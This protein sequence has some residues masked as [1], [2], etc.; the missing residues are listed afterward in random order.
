[1]EAGLWFLPALRQVYRRKCTFYNLCPKRTIK[2]V[3]SVLRFE[4][5]DL[6]WKILFLFFCASLCTLDLLALNIQE[7]KFVSEHFTFC[8]CV[9]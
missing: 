2:V 5:V 1:M 6:K 9:C 8:V 3:S 7:E 4:F